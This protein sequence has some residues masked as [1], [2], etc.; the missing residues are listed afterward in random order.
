MAADS[1]ADPRFDH[2][3]RS[4]EVLAY[5]PRLHSCQSLD[6]FHSAPE[7]EAEVLPCQIQA[8]LGGVA[9]NFE[10]VAF[11]TTGNSGHLKDPCAHIHHYCGHLDALPDDRPGV[12]NHPLSQAHSSWALVDPCCGHISLEEHLHGFDLHGELSLS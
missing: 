2:M 6:H 9:A 1:L 11:H 8:R 10:E 12:H 4:S 7:E 3:S 5:S